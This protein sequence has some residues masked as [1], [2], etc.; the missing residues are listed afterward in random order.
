MP[1]DQVII[2]H[3]E[4]VR[5]KRDDVKLQLII[6]GPVEQEYLKQYV[7]QLALETDEENL[8]FPEEYGVED[9]KPTIEDLTNDQMRMAHWILS[10]RARWDK[11]FQKLARKK[12][13]TFN[14]SRKLTLH[15]IA[16]SETGYSEDSYGFYGDEL[17]IEVI[18]DTTAVLLI[19]N[20]IRKY[21]E[22]RTSID[23][24]TL[25]D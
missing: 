2:L 25:N 18:N 11:V 9:D 14:K 5:V 7:A 12:N 21:D 22:G 10:E 1:E 20:T 15:R 16:T 19:Q 4:T 17:R 13:G 24:M 23:P 3:E 8:Y 6:P